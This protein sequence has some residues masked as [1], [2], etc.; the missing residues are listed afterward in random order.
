[1]INQYYVPFDP[2]LDCLTSI[3][4]TGDKIDT[5]LQDLQALNDVLANGAQT[6]G[7]QPCS[8]TSPATSSARTSPTCRGDRSGA[9]ASKRARPTRDRARRRA[10]DPRHPVGIDA[11]AGGLGDA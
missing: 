5:L 11:G 4:L 10:R 8:R 2:S 3:G 7:Y 1:M 6:F 9:P